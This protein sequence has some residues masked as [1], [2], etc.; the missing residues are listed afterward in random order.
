MERSPWMR[1]MASWPACRRMWNAREVW[2]SH[3][4]FAGPKRVEIFE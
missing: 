3:Q 2:C 4:T 1:S